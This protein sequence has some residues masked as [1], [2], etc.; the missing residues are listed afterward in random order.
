MCI[1][2]QHLNVKLLHIIQQFWIHFFLSV[3]VDRL[4]FV[5]IRRNLCQT[6]LHSS[7]AAEIARIQ[8]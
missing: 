8:R 1:I 5:K 4:A 3:G 6:L 2:L 7:Y